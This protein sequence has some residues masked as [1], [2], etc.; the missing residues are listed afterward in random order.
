VSIV[1]IVFFVLNVFSVWGVPKALTTKGGGAAAI[2]S[3]KEDLK[4]F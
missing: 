2:F 3:V 1:F 4:N